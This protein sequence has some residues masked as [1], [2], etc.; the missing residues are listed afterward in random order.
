MKR[1]ILL[2]SCLLVFVLGCNLFSSANALTFDVGTKVSESDFPDEDKWHYFNS[3]CMVRARP[4]YINYTTLIFDGNKSTGIDHYFGADSKYGYMNIY[5]DF[6]FPFNVSNI[7]IKS[8]FNGSFAKGY[9]SV[10]FGVYSSSQSWQIPINKTLQINGRVRGLHL[11]LHND[12]TNHFYFNDIII[13]Y[14]INLTDLSSINQALNILQNSINSIQNQ[15]NNLA[16][17][18]NELN[19]LIIELNNSIADI[20]Y[21]R[22]LILENITNL[23]TVCNGLNN[24]IQ[25]FKIDINNL[26]ST[27][28]QNITQLESNLI[29]IEKDINNIQKNIENLTLDI[30]QLPVLK[31]QINK[32]INDILNLN[33]NLTLLQESI[34]DEYDDT[35]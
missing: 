32:T 8:A 19:N 27:I 35:A 1:S 15:I 6:P 22:Q 10:Y 12:G 28:Y 20:N 23:W 5:I 11:Q 18:F 2:I 14:T 7:T 16:N 9:L 3:G 30:D 26:N 13:N 17:Q 24:T 25:K 31:D 21:T 34:P 4:E 29:I 33:Q